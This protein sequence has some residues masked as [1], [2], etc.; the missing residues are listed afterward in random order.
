MHH[1]R[2]ETWQ[3]QSVNMKKGKH[4]KKNSSLN[5]FISIMLCSTYALIVYTQLVHAL[6]KQEHTHYS[7]HVWKAVCITV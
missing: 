1:S 5:N 7:S 6:H 3:K 4:Y 2:I